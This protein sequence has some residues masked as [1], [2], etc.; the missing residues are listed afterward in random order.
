MSEELA[1]T[2]TPPEDPPRGLVVFARTAEELSAGHAKFL[3]WVSEWKEA[4]SHEQKGLGKTIAAFKANKWNWKA[5]IPRGASLKKQREFYEKLED[6]L[7]LGYMVVP[8]MGMEV[9]AIRTAAWCPR[10]RAWRGPEQAAQLLPAGEGE[11][12]N[13]NPTLRSEHTGN[14]AKGEPQYRNVPHRWRESPDFPLELAIPAVMDATAQALAM[15]LFDELGVVRDGD[16]ATRTSNRGDP[17]ILGRI[18]NPRGRHHVSF[19]I[20]WAFDA[21][22]IA[23]R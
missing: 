13:P 18:L 3:S 20:A 21:K 2:A 9:F 5:L 11:N 1:T 23:P 6:A 14:N 4:I 15:K 7:K 8:N 17:M 12:R 16:R 19:F 22:E 10:D